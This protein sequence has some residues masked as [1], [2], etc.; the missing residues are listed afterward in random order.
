MI[1][2]YGDSIIMAL[3]SGLVMSGIAYPTLAKVKGWPRGQWHETENYYIFFGELY[4]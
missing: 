4:T 3:I 2:G 1:Y